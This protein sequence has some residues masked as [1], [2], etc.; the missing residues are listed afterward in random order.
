MNTENATDFV[1]AR[2][3]DDL[4]VGRVGIF[5]QPCLA[6]ELGDFPI[7]ENIFQKQKSVLFIKLLIL[8]R[9]LSSIT[10]ADRSALG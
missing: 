5:D 7:A 6:A 4:F 8:G 2:F 9:D 3:R 10:G 1:A